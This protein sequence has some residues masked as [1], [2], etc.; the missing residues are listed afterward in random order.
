MAQTFAGED[1]AVSAKV[2]A[3]QTSFTDN[4]QLMLTVVI[5]LRVRPLRAIACDFVASVPYDNSS[6]TA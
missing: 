4:K 3:F 1:A 6:R 2:A 5:R